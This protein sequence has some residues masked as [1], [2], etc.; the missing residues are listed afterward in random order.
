MSLEEIHRRLKEPFEPSA[1]HWRVGATTKDKKKGIA[2][3]YLDARDVMDRLDEVVGFEGWKDS[4]HAEPPRSVRKEDRKATPKVHYMEQIPGRVICTISI[5][6]DGHWISKSDGAGETAVEGEKGGISDA[7]KRCAVKWG[8]GRYLYRL[9]NIWVELDQYKKII[10]TPKLPPEAIPGPRV[11]LAEHTAAVRDNWNSIVA[12]KDA[13]NSSD[14][15]ELKVN[16]AEAWFELD[17]AVKEKLWLSTRDGGI[18]T[19]AERKFIK[20]E[21]RSHLT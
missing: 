8:I 16:G 17:N 1:I 3:A 13:V 18:W 9:S 15:E 19:P 2:L 10:Q 6:I 11:T 20:E 14:D 5:L 21:L 12:V 7:F 4:Y